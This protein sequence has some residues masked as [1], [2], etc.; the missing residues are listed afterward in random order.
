M[1]ALASCVVGPE[2][3]ESWKGHPVDSLIFAWGP[4]M[5]DARPPDGRR[6]LVYSGSY[7]D[8]VEETSLYC[9]AIFRADPTGMI[10]DASTTGNIGGCNRLLSSKPAAM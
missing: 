4:P 3:V 1:I 8:E 2:R 9:N 6:V 5:Q 7:E 10:V